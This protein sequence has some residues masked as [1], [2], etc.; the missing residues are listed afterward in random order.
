[1]LTNLPKNLDRVISEHS[2]A[3]NRVCFQ[4]NNGFILLSA[5]QDGNIKAWV[6]ILESICSSTCQI[7]DISNLIKDLRDPKAAAK[8]SYEGKSESVRDVQFNPMHT[9]EFAAGFE[10]GTIQVKITSFIQCMAYL[11]H[12]L[13]PIEMGYAKSKINI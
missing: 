11:A 7:I 5:S 12:N 4:P 6:I 2:R 8:Y 13:I 1:M 10:T 3:V 9:H